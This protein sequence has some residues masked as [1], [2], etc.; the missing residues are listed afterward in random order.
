MA[1]PSN[2]NRIIVATY[3]VL[4]SHLA[5]PSY[6]AHCTESNLSAKKRLPRVLEKLESLV[7]QEAVICL[8]EVSMAWAGTFHTWFQNRGYHFTSSLYG[9][10]F[11]GY[12][13]IGIAFPN[14]RF[15]AVDIDL[16]RISDVKWW[17]RQPK[18]TTIPVVE[19]V[20]R[21]ILDSIGW[22][23]EKLA[24]AKNYVFGETIEHD[25]WDISKSRQNTMVS[26]K[27]QPVGGGAA[28]A[29]STYHMPCAYYAPNVMLIHTAL[30]AQHALKFAGV[31]P[32]ILAGDWNTKPNDPAYTLLTTAALPRPDMAP[33]YLDNDKWRLEDGLTPLV[34]AYAAV[35]GKEPDFTNYAQ[36][37]EDPCFIECLDYIFSTPNITPV[38]VQSLPH[39][40]SIVGPLPTRDEPSDHILISATYDLDG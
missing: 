39:R 36:I 6:F 20:V 4:S 12:M 10:P 33:T 11:N 30:A 27:L 31:T 8:Q 40:D 28:V 37:R 5:S 24:S 18:P 9:K 29:V 1:S 15:E 19:F 13:G 25:Y 34:S 38:A 35:Q 2:D 23:L 22:M 16:K 3:N 7:E 26:V 21:P 14:K 32:M 17:P